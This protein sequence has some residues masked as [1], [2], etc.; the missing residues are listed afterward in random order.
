MNK[1]RHREEGSEEE[2]TVVMKERTVINLNLI[3]THGK[4]AEEHGRF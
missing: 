2:K 1:G 4:E 3:R